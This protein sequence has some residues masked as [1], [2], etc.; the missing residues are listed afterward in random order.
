MHS[1]RPRHP[2]ILYTG[3]IY[4]D[5]IDIDEIDVSFI[6]CY[7]HLYMKCFSIYT[8]LHLQH[9]LNLSNTVFLPLLYTTLTYYF[10][11]DNNDVSH[12]APSPVSA[13]QH[14]HTYTAAGS[15]PMPPH[16][17]SLLLLLLCIHSSCQPISGPHQRARLPVP[18]CPCYNLALRAAVS[19]LAAATAVA[20]GQQA[21]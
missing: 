13:T 1:P 7:L 12:G 2:D 3:Y 8:N 4:I 18:T 11:V 15:R 6:K 16:T 17:T 10:K 21:L 14:T 5:E 9:L 20:P 19:H